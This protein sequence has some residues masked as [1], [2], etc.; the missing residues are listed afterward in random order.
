MDSIV[1]GEESG[2][3]SDDWAYHLLSIT[4]D[5]AG[6]ALIP[7]DGGKEWRYFFGEESDGVAIQIADE[8]IDFVFVGLGVHDDFVDGDPG[9]N[10]N[11]LVGSGESG[12]HWLSMVC[13]GDRVGWRS[14]IGGCNAPGRDR[15][16][17]WGWRRCL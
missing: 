8:Q 11:I 5:E 12:D 9:F 3:G 14:S 15:R 2:V 7:S 13:G 4:V 16:C 10:A 6:F 1:L 17:G